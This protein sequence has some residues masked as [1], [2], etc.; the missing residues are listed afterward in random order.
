MRWKLPALCKTYA[1]SVQ[2]MDRQ[3]GRL[4]DYLEA[5]DLMDNTIVCF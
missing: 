2:S 3:I 1:A 5:N 4:L